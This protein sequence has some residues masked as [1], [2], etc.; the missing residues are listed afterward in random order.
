MING[1]RNTINN[2]DGDDS[3]QILGRPIFFDCR[4]EAR[5][6]FQHSRGSPNFAACRQKCFDQRLKMR[7]ND[8]AIDQQCFGSTTD[9][10]SAHFG[11]QYNILRH[12][13]IG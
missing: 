3:V 6:D 2:R 11:V 1:T 7:A 9:S 13:E 8:R 4:F 5:N 12:V 10:G